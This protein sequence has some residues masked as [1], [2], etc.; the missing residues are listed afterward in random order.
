MASMAR[1]E[2]AADSIPVALV[3][4]VLVMAV[5]TGLAAIGLTNAGPA[6]QMA[7]VDR[8]VSAMANDCRLL[9]SMAPRNLDDPCSPQGAF[10]AIE[11]DLPD[12]LEYLSFGYDPDSGGGHEGT[13]YFKV[14]GTKK[15]IIVDERAMFLAADDSYTILS[16]G[17]YDLYVEHARDALGHRYLLIFCQR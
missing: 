12:G 8:Q 16:S 5:I 15:A 4:T 2:S 14:C 7:A 9:L 11:L 17:R 3:A 1:D 6:I 10:R 13:I